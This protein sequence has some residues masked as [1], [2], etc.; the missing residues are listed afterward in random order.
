M[1]AK[2][3]RS[4]I[5][6]H[7]MAVV[8]AVMVI[9][10][11]NYFRGG[12][13]FSSSN[14]NLIFNL[15]P[16]LMLFGFIIKGGEAL[17]IYRTLSSKKK[18]TK[19]VVHT[20]V[21]TIALLLAFLGLYAVF[22]YHIESGTPNMYSLHGWLGIVIV[23]LY[24]IQWVYGFSVFLYPG[25]SSSLRSKSLHWHMKFGLSLFI[26]AIGN[27]VLGFVEKLTFLENAGLAKFSPEAIFVNFTAIATLLFGVF[28]VI[29][30]ISD[31]P[32]AEAAQ[33]TEEFNGYAPLTYEC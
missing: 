16:L 33:T 7:I 22:K 20:V 29:T 3:S 18:I 32:A 8:S 19:K 27:A 23:A 2:G 24:A 11:C 31:Q 4:A 25:G 13:S 30:A 9:F 12:L 17:I 6:V 28:V 26:F 14:K 1:G 21:H 10:W 15:H 5:V